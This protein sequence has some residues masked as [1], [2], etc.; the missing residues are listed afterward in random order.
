MQSQK[1]LLTATFAI[2]L[3]S[4]A[5]LAFADDALLSAQSG[6]GD[7]RWQC[8]PAHESVLPSK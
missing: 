2:G 5:S 3:G 8:H 4:L 7:R 6:Q 1:S